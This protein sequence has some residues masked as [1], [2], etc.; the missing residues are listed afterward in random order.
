M[1]INEQKAIPTR[2]SEFGLEISLLCVV[3]LTS[4]TAFALKAFQTVD[5]KEKTRV[6]L[7][8]EHVK[9]LAEQ[10]LVVQTR[11]KLPGAWWKPEHAHDM[12]NLR[13]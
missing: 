3:D 9:G 11:L 4:N 7:H 2:V 6:D 5:V 8:A 13:T 10:R 12:L 1:L